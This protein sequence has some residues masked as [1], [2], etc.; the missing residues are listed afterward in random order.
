[1]VG[2][3]L[4]M[5]ARLASVLEDQGGERDTDGR[6]LEEGEEEDC[7]VGGTHGALSLED[8][9]TV[10]QPGTVSS[11][12]RSRPEGEVPGEGQQREGEEEGAEGQGRG[13]ECVISEDGEYD[14]DLEMEGEAGAYDPTG[15]ASYREACRTIGVV[16]ASYALRHLQS[17]ELIMMHHGL[18]PQGTKALAVPLVTNTSI[19]KLNLRDN[20]M[21]GMGGVA[22]ADML[23]ENCYITDVDLSE[24]QLGERGAW[25]LASTLQEN[26]TLVRLGLAGNQL[27][28]GA[29][30]PLARA[31]TS[32][33]RLESLDLSHNS[34]G[35]EAGKVLGPA[36]A[37][38]TGLRH[39]SLAWNCLRGRGAVALAA[40]LGANIFLRSLD[41]SY[42]GF[43]R[44][45]AVSLGEA[46]KDNNT[47][48]ELDISN[49]R[50][51]PE[52]AIRFTMGLRVNK[53]IRALRMGRN[54]IQ[55]AGCYGVLKSIQEN[56]Q[57]A[58]ESLD[59]SDIPVNQDFEDLL[60]SMKDAFPNLTV[61]HGGRIDTFRKA[62]R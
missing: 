39:L 22:V 35:E 37:E 19:L 32:N 10:T 16:P 24:N 6:G 9:Q 29:G 44:E 55:T 34:L 40:G 43:G 25:A 7:R 27:G 21:E 61:K 60:S 54:P 42:N 33:T 59:F 50:I 14:T 1:M 52:G 49:N 2:K 11:G 15:Q 45:G 38:N 12:R 58:V 4:V 41:L 53:T 28:D 36:L 48:E 30:R 47:L 57:S 26:S 18:G 51:P 23:K 62:K 17:S 3:K 56:S 46:L 20:W 8:G 5:E 31:L 13:T